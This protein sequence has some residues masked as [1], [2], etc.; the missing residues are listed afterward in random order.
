MDI[1][2]DSQRVREEDVEQEGEEEETPQDTLTESHES[3]QTDKIDA[4]MITPVKVGGRGGAGAAPCRVA[5]LPSQLVWKRLAGREG[6]CRKGTT[7]WPPLQFYPA[8]QIRVMTA[9]MLRRRYLPLL[10]ALRLDTGLVHPFRPTRERV[11]GTISVNN[12]TTLTGLHGS[13]TKD[14]TVRLGDQWF[15]RQRIFAIPSAVSSSS[16]LRL[17]ALVAAI[18]TAAGSLVFPASPTGASMYTTPALN[19]EYISILELGLAER[20]RLG[21]IRSELGWSWV[22][23]RTRITHSGKRSRPLRRLCSKG[24]ASQAIA[25]KATTTSSGSASR[26]EHRGRSN[27]AIT[28]SRSGDY[29]G[30]PIEA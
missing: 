28:T 8:R 27:A 15:G 25:S 18:A 6:G 5:V 23:A 2:I 7:A 12:P 13:W 3:Q 14:H 29:R 4:L 22:S 1:G 30:K 16:S 24:A 17:P 26:E 9:R 10:M 20:D 19:F 21:G 11:R